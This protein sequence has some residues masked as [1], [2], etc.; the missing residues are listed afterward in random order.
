M[1][2]PLWVPIKHRAPTAVRPRSYARRCPY[3]FLRSY[4]KLSETGYSSNIILKP[5]KQLQ[6]IHVYLWLKNKMSSLEA[7]ASSFLRDHQ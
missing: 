3:R 1:G 5:K 6:F 2:I 7:R 4:Q